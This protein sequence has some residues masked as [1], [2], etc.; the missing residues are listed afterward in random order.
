MCSDCSSCWSDD[1]DLI[2]CSCCNCCLLESRFLIVQGCIPGYDLFCKR[3]HPP[4]LRQQW[5]QGRRPQLRNL[6]R[7][8]QARCREPNASWCFEYIVF[9]VNCFENPVKVCRLKAMPWV[10]IGLV[11]DQDPASYHDPK[12]KLQATYLQTRSDGGPPASDK[13]LALV[14]IQCAVFSCFL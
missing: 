4:L 10:Y 1:N 9:N 13:K 7:Q 8:R 12:P 14:S 2:C 11:T 3:Q 5:V 6:A